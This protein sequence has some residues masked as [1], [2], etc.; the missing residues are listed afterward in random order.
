MSSKRPLRHGA[1]AFE[2]RERL[3][4][5]LFE[6]QAGLCHLCGEPMTMQRKRGT[7][8]GK[9]FATF[10][11]VVPASEGGTAYYLNLK[12]AHRACNNARNS[13]PIESAARTT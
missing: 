2:R 4:V 10:D 12:L 8:V 13:R 1:D 6:K 9:N 5:Q 11:H 3:R 7:V